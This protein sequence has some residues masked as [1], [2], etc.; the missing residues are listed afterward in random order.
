MRRPAYEITYPHPHNPA[1]PTYGASRRTAPSVP[2]RVRLDAPKPTNPEP[3][4]AS[5]TLH[6]LASPSPDSIRWISMPRPKLSSTAVAL[7]VVAAL[8]A[9]NLCATL[10]RSDSH[11]IVL[12]TLVLIR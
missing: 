4:A 7:Y 3:S 5:R 2:R 12:A 8:L 10:V 11:K 9:A 6:F 1:T